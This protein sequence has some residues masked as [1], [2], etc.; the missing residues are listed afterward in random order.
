MKQGA[1]GKQDEEPIE[2]LPVEWDFRWVGSEDEASEVYLLELSR[3]VLRQAE[4]RLKGRREKRALDDLVE[5]LVFPANG[6]PS[7]K[8]S[9]AIQSLKKADFLAGVLM[10]YAGQATGALGRLQPAIQLSK[11]TQAAASQQRTPIVGVRTLSPGETFRSFGFSGE[12]CLVV[13]I[14]KG[15]SSS[16]AK[17]VFAVWA[18]ANLPS[19]AVDPGGRPPSPSVKLMRLAFFRFEQRWEHPR[20]YAGFAVAVRTQ[21]K[22]GLSSSFTDFGNRCYAPFMNVKANQPKP[23]S[24]TEYVAKARDELEPLI[25]EVVEV[26]KSLD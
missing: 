11:R 21:A 6:L 9:A 20:P 5:S 14:P 10:T 4:R 16:M 1:K 12:T 7:R 25:A 13:K 2:L 22:G 15:V 19:G 26:A 3:E 24:W 8:A 17:D 18:D 23:S